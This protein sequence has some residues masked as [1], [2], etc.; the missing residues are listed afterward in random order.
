MK[1]IL[2]ICIFFF[3]LTAVEAL[4]P[5]LS[6]LQKLPILELIKLKDLKTDAYG[7][8]V[9]I[10]P[11]LLKGWVYQTGPSTRPGY[12]LGLFP[13]TYDFKPFMSSLK[14]NGFPELFLTKTIFIYSKQAQTIAI[15]KLPQ[16]FQKALKSF[17]A[18]M[19]AVVL[20][21]GVN[22]F[23]VMDFNKSLSVKML[24]PNAG[25]K[26]NLVKLQG[27]VMPAIFQHFLTK[28]VTRK[29][30]S[31]L[32][33]TIGTLELSGRLPVLNPTGLTNVFKFQ[34]SRLLIKGEL[35]KSK[36]PVIRTTIPTAFGLTINSKKHL[37]EGNILL[38]KREKSGF[39]MTLACRALGTWQNP[40]GIKTLGLISV[41]DFELKNFDIALDLSRA[42]SNKTQT[43]E[44]VIK[45]NMKPA[46]DVI[47]V[48]LPAKYV[49]GKLEK[50]R[51][52]VPG[53]I[54]LGVFAGIKLIPGIKKFVFTEVEI[55]KQA[56]GGTFAWNILKIPSRAVIYFDPNNS[57]NL[58]LFYR[59]KDLKA[60]KLI[61]IKLLPNKTVRK[62]AQTIFDLFIFPEMIVT[63]SV[64]GFNYEVSY[65][66][67]SVQ[68]ILKG[69]AGNPDYVLKVE[70]N[71]SLVTSW[72]PTTARGLLGKILKTLGLQNPMMLIGTI[73]GLFGGKL[74]VK[75]EAILP[76]IPVTFFLPK[77]WQFVK[78][79]GIAYFTRL[80]A[81][82]DLDIGY[83]GSVDIK[84][85]GIDQP[86][87]R[88]STEV[89]SFLGLL[90]PAGGF[91]V[92]L[93]RQGNWLNPFGLYGLVMKDS[94]CKFTMESDTTFGFVMSSEATV[95][96]DRYKLDALGSFNAATCGMPKEFI[97]NLETD[98]LGLRS[99]MGVADVAMKSITESPI[100]RKLIVGNIKDKTKKA[101]ANKF[102]D[103]V[104]GDAHLYD[105]LKLDNFPAFSLKD[106]QIYL[107]TP[108]A[109]D[110]DLKL[111]GAGAAV[112]GQLWFLG[113]QLGA[114]HGALTLR[115]LKMM[116]SITLPP[117]GPVQLKESM[118]DISANLNEAPH[119]IARGK[120]KFFGYNGERELQ[121]SKDK[122]RLY[123]ED[124]LD[125]LWHYKFEA[126]SIGED[127]LHVKDFTVNSKLS[128]DFSEY[129]DKTVRGD[130]NAFAK[131]LDKDYQ[132][133]LKNLKKAQAKVKGLDKKIKDMR[134]KVKKDQ[135]RILSKVRKAEA[136]VNGLK[137]KIASVKRRKI[138]KDFWY[139]K[140]KAKQAAELA[141][142]GTAYGTAKAALYTARK[143]V[144]AGNK[145]VPIDLDPR[146]VGL[147]TARGVATVALK[148]A[149]VAV[150]VAKG[151]NS[152]INKAFNAV[153]DGVSKVRILA[154][155]K[156]NFTG[157]SLVKLL[158]NQ[159]ADLD[160]HL[161][162]FGK[163]NLRVQEKLYLINP[164]IEELAKRISKKVIDI[165]KK[166][167]LKTESAPVTPGKPGGQQVAASTKKL[168]GQQAAG[169]W[170]KLPGAGMD[171]G[172]GA[173][174]D[175]WCVG[176]NQAPYRWD[177]RAWRKY[178]GGIIKVDVDPKGQ[179]WGVNSA[180]MIYVMDVRAKKWKNLPGRAKD[181]GCGGRGRGVTCIIGT[182]KHTYKW[183]GRKWID[184]GGAAKRVDV[185][186]NG[187]PWVVN[188]A[189]VIYWYEVNRKKW[190]HIPTGRAIDIT[191]G[192]DGSIWVLGTNKIVYK[193]D[194]KNWI[195]GNGAGYHITVDN[196]GLPWVI[197]MDRATWR[198]TR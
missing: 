137:S 151:A 144:Q 154:I 183:D 28:T 69:V 74:G 62:I 196:R 63:L 148:T 128:S 25:S 185:D 107:A 27:T 9:L 4:P 126:T 87:V 123:W 130:L 57:S 26:E 66:P 138:K 86:P 97:I 65:L 111:E 70:K 77:E 17:D 192:S 51:F 60:S 21:S 168:R 177:G 89:T 188:D 80:N 121:F 189:G 198:R 122:V 173:K 8:S 113:K 169:T 180:G 50:L 20:K 49:K 14:L 114:I 141:G 142:L 75:F 93:R 146:V 61:P 127:L 38:K 184:F 33:A 125:K 106:T 90:S 161:L 47:P 53:E 145:I 32:T 44:F 153:M 181:I 19:K 16:S 48:E 194:G 108:G 92:T 178:P 39:D 6:S 174:G 82:G 43:L 46:K 11:K 55:S 52:I 149:E 68:D 160:I 104:K 191:C 91:G 175:A 98:E 120:A 71:L 110:P 164:K 67:E 40:L 15:T 134:A 1:R 81:L 7:T 72:D 140:N 190:H 124:D 73:E 96:G 35:D 133:A 162:V 42:M 186:K 187:N 166:K 193:W 13:G 34:N 100:T 3:C 83:R 139:L 150:K 56:I 24:K 159:P 152:G 84:A 167:E 118:L 41:K 94:F 37:F 135:D 112:K 132:K 129:L 109:S 79:F 119:F 88:F 54:D 116:G 195:K 158:K 163:Y 155:K 117:I 143:A 165:F 99:Y 131:N 101:A 115:G 103:A 2:F 179:P 136:K 157:G 85:S 45:S 76:A 12:I 176:I 29:S 78:D 64:K 22:F 170:K 171:I 197:G 147:K 156:A 5:Q 105:R 59:I 10:G 95:S 58:T 31:T 18:T 102:L 23:S 30:M 182:N 172:V 36:K